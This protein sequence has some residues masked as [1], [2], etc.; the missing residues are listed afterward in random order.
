MNVWRRATAGLVVVAALSAR[1][2]VAQ[3]IALIVS[4]LKADSMA[5][6]PNFTVTALPGG[7]GAYAVTLEMSTEAA[8][9]RPFY[10]AGN[11]GLLG[12]FAIDSLLPEKTRIFMRARLF[13]GGVVVA[14]QQQQH[15]VQAWVR[16]ID[17]PQQALANLRTRRPRFVWQSPAIT[18]PPG[19]W[20][21]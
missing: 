7:P 1:P 11:D 10:V 14:E 20:Q 4:N 16:L 5:P 21:Y 2:V 6:A 3:S 18:L 9:A 15:T 19:P 12:T 13:N 17:P 8:F